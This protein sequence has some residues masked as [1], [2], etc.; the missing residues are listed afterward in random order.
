MPG[1]GLRGLLAL[2]LPSLT[3]PS[4][5]VQRRPQ[6]LQSWLFPQLTAELEAGGPWAASRKAG[7]AERRVG[8]NTSRC[9]NGRGS[10]C[11]GTGWGQVL[12]LLG[13]QPGRPNQ[14]TA[15]AC[16]SL[17]QAWGQD[18]RK[19]DTGPASG[20]SPFWESS[21]IS[22]WQEDM[23]LRKFGCVGKVCQHPFRG[24]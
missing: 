14:P 2:F 7:P 15:S 12:R 22:M 18:P 16:E 13:S 24:C 3:L 8:L 11:H 1:S 20:D 4:A 19:G 9:R 5:S 21:E 17:V 6:S 10:G 23:V